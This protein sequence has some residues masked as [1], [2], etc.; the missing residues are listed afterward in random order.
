MKRINVLFFLLTAIFIFSM[1]FKHANVAGTF[2]S[3]NKNIL[4]HQITSFLNNAEVKLP[5]SKIV[6]IIVPH[7][8]YRYS[9]QTEA[10]GFKAL[11]TNNYAQYKR[12]IIIGPTHYFEFN[13]LAIPKF[14]VYILPNG[15]CNIDIKAEK[16]LKK[17][18]SFIMK[19]TFFYKEHSIETA[20]PFL[21]VI[22]PDIP[23]VPIIVGKITNA[24]MDDIIKDL[25]PFLKDSL[26]VISS[27]L[28]H[29]KP[30]DIVK[31][32]D[33]RIL[34]LIK[35]KDPETML[36]ESLS[37]KVQACGLYPIYIFLNLIKNN[38]E[39]KGKILHITD[40]GETS[41]GDDRVIGYGSMVFYKELKKK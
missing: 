16:I 19:D 30:K 33:E 22:Y 17:N 4:N 15:N 21:N 38:E 39:I 14:S 23:I 6:G 41:L 24:M 29:N 8:G 1:D 26:F 20:L 13:G 25:K 11:Q 7:A 2:Y 3:D 36:K 5:K 34:E 12:I 9:G 35:E 28:M 18:R 40:S 37:G 10:Y 31:K 27:D 32:S